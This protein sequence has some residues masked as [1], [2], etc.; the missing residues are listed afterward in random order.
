[1]PFDESR[2][3]R[4]ALQQWETEFRATMLDFA[5]RNP[6]QF[7]RGPSALLEQAPNKRQES[8][9]RTQERRML[10]QIT[11][12]TAFEAALEERV[13]RTSFA[14]TLDLMTSGRSPR[15]RDREATNGY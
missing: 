2:I 12:P 1:M 13:A 8:A 15:D 11:D 3:A 14:E 4:D 6:A 5:R 9:A 7:R 10:E